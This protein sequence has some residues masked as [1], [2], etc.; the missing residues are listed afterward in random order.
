MEKG[1]KLDIS[2][3]GG[4]VNIGN[5]ADYTG[6]DGLT[7]HATNGGIVHM[8]TRTIY[9]LLIWNHLLPLKG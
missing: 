5:F 1:S 3:N 4:T 6:G 9:S 7:V 2:L 8:G